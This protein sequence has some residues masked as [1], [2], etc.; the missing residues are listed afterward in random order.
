[1]KTFKF[2]FRVLVALIA[3]ILP[4]AGTEAADNFRKAGVITS[5]GYDQF[6]TYRQKYRFAPGAKINSEDEKRQKFSDF[7]PGDEIYFEGVI[8]NGVFYVNIIYYETPTPS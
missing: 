2:K 4:W 8:L 3:F 7:R 6:T 1:M 5:V